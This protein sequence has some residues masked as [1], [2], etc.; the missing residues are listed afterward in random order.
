MPRVP[1]APE[2]GPS[3]AYQRHDFLAFLSVPVVIRLGRFH[4]RG[5]AWAVLLGIALI[6]AAAIAS[7]MFIANLARW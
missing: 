5:P 3:P 2:T 7:P 4:I 6:V 1:Q